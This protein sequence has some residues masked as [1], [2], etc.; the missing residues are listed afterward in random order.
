[1]VNKNTQLI[2]QRWQE[3]REYS[4]LTPGLSVTVERK[5]LG[6][7][8]YPLYW[9]NCV[10]LIIDLEETINLGVLRYFCEGNSKNVL[11]QSVVY[12]IA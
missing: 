11:G 3:F 2:Q 10:A 5:R 12:K 7:H 1:M 9:F 8:C 4:L 6:F